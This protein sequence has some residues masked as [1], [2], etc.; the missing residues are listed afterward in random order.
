MGK[1]LQE[2][3]NGNKEV[4]FSFALSPRSEKDC[5]IKPVKLQFSDAR[6]EGSA[7]AEKELTKNDNKK[8]IL[9]K[10]AVP[11]K[12][13]KGEKSN[14][15]ASVGKLQDEF[16]IKLD[17]EELALTDE[18]RA[19]NNLLQIKFKKPK[20][21]REF[22]IKR[23]LA[24]LK[25]IKAIYKDIQ[26][27]EDRKDEDLDICPQYGERLF[28]GS[29]GTRIWRQLDIN[30]MKLEKRRQ[31]KAHSRP[32]GRSVTV[33]FNGK[34]CL[35]GEREV[36]S[37]PPVESLDDGKVSVV[38]HGEYF[39]LHMFAIEVRRAGRFVHKVNDEVVTVRISRATKN[40]L[41]KFDEVPVE[42][43]ESDMLL[44]VPKRS[45]FT[46][47]N[48]SRVGTAVV[49]AEISIYTSSFN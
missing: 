37:R 22:F 2:Q 31:N 47:E 12:D 48:N 17:S 20:G 19:L 34:S 6:V 11:T 7:E 23:D 4:V 30:A 49:K 32:Q 40:S 39:N 36:S 29:D 25:S 13:K 21:N 27:D 26:I 8:K 3:V 45:S 42:N 28:T 16:Y 35:V 38:Y 5:Q 1:V 43:I 15:R 10:S 46:I 9:K 18:Q 44:F 14:K 24:F 41:V 33:E